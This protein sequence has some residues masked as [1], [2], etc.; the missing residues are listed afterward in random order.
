[1]KK[2]CVLLSG[3]SLCGDEELYEALQNIAVVV[4]NPENSQV[5]ALMATR[6]V[7]LVI[8]EIPR[9]HPADVDLIKHLRQQFPD[10]VI[11][12]VDGDADRKVIARAFSYG[13]NDAFRKPYH[14]VL[15][16][17]RVKAILSRM[18]ID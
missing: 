10:I 11:I 18:S 15:M 14:R 13:A 3:D 17:E 12:V 16:V 5:E 9:K 6:P 7:D 1:M 8:L 4:K 2:R